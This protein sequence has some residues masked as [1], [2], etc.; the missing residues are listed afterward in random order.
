MSHDSIYRHLHSYLSFFEE[1][2]ITSPCLRLREP[3]TKNLGVYY[4]LHTMA[5]LLFFY[6]FSFFFSC[7][8]VCLFPVCSVF[9]RFPLHAP[10]LFVFFRLS[11]LIFTFLRF[12]FDFRSIG[13]LCFSEFSPQIFSGVFLW[14]F[15][16]YVRA[17]T[18]FVHVIF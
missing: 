7:S 11:S 3:T 13:S 17:Y 2:L 8:A 4:D 10:F 9:F 16:K 15:F 14:T 12:C 1:H 5:S 6:L 18:R